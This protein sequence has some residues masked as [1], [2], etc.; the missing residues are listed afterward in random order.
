MSCSASQ[1]ESDGEDVCVPSGEPDLRLDLVSDPRM[2]APVRGLVDALS[3][4][5]GF[6]DINSAHISLAVDEVLANVIRHGYERRPDGRIFLRI[7]CL[8][9]TRPGVTIVIEDH[10]K[11]VDPECFRGRD[12]EDIRPGGL[13]VH[14]VREV[15]DGCRFERREGPG[16]RA[17]LVKWLPATA[18]R[19]DDGTPSTE[20]NRQ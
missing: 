4:R 1:H 16:M 11:Q 8:E 10:G 3:H 13:G 6:C 5:I 19:V 12:L 14:I 7:W 18:D 20:N 15:M 17:V 2:L 9:I